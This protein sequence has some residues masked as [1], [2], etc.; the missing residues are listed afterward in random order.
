LIVTPGFPALT[1]R[2]FVIVLKGLAAVPLPVMS[3]PPT[4]LTKISVV[5]DLS[6]ELPSVLPDV[7][8]ALTTK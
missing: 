4:A 6:T 8:W 2:A 3:F 1:A 5:T 7:S